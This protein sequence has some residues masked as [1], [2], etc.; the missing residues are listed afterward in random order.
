MIVTR[1][2]TK[3][4]PRAFCFPK[5]CSAPPEMAPE[6]PALD[7][8]CNNTTTI[9]DNATITSKVISNTC[10][11]FHLLIETPQLHTFYQIDE[12]VTT[13]NLIGSICN[14]SF[15]PVFSVGVSVECRR[16]ICLPMIW[17][18]SCEVART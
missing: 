4:S 11:L 7:P 2:R 12:N 5:S 1:W 16:S 17:Q 14:W 6:R 13:V 18:T 9:N 3:S 15:P 8:D 10:I